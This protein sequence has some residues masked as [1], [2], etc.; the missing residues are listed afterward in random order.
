PAAPAA[1]AAPGGRFPYVLLAGIG[2]IGAVAAVVGI[3]LFLVLGDGDDGTPGVAGGPKATESSDETRTPRPTGTPRIEPT[4]PIPP[5]QAVPPGPVPR[6]LRIEAPST[7][8]A[9]DIITITVGAVNEGDDAEGGSISVSLPDDPELIS[10]PVPDNSKL[11][12]DDIGVYRE[13]D[14]TSDI[15]RAKDVLA[16]SYWGPQDDGWPSG[17][18]REMS[19][20]LKVSDVDM[21]ELAVRVSMKELGNPCIRTHPGGSQTDDR[22]QQDYPVIVRRIIV[23]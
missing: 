4:V 18:R 22:D 11:V 19:F 1:P 13:A 17:L 2:G 8:E 3:V 16:E 15:V 7:V 21:L 10:R 20:R 6:L 23:E 14:C 12:N 9:G 5:A